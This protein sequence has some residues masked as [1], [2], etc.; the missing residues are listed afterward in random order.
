MEKIKK[1]EEVMDF[2]GNHLLVSLD[3]I[4]VYITYIIGSNIK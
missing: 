1:S 3:F 2:S 4:L